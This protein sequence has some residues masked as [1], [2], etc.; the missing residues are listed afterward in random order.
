MLL[1]SVLHKV[2]SGKNGYPCWNGYVQINQCLLHFLKNLLTL[3]LSNHT[4]IF[5][6]IPKRWYL[7]L[8][9][10]QEEENP[11]TTVHGIHI[12]TCLLLIPFQQ[13]W[14]G[15]KKC[16]S[17]VTY[18]KIWNTCKENFDC[19]QYLYFFKETV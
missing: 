13:T 2:L 17:V 10:R 1:K 16:W 11:N 19:H 8:G 4:S 3:S 18:F 7:N 14:E 6:F 9:R 12:Q 5:S 15:A